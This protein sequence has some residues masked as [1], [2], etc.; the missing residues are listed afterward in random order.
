MWHNYYLRFAC[1]LRSN[2]NEQRHLTQ[3][4]TDLCYETTIKSIICSALET[5]V[6]VLTMDTDEAFAQWCTAMAK[7][8]CAYLVPLSEKGE[9]Y[10]HE[11]SF[12]LRR[13]TTSKSINY[14]K[15]LISFSW[16]YGREGNSQ[17]RGPTATGASTLVT[18]KSARLLRFFRPR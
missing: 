12:V 4:E 2:G 10:Y 1:W 14:S 16:A 5:K 11:N 15:L 3:I 13:I 8:Y 7:R 6:D 18:V 17:T 9:V